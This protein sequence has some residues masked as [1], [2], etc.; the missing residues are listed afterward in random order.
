VFVVLLVIIVPTP[1]KDCICFNNGKS[2]VCNVMEKIALTCHPNLYSLF[3]YIET[4][5][6]A[7]P[8]EKPTTNQGSISYLLLGL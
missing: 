4:K 8:S 5:N 6:D 3:L 1:K 2:L 7:Y